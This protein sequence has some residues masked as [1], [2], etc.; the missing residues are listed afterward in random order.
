VPAQGVFYL[1]AVQGAVA[2][3]IGGDFLNSG[4]FVVVF[5]DEFAAALD[6]VGIEQARSVQL[7]SIRIG[8]D[9]FVGV[10]KVFGVDGPFLAVIGVGREVEKRHGNSPFLLFFP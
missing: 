9:E 7:G 10:L 6:T 1:P 4:R 3:M 2:P 8:S 5:G